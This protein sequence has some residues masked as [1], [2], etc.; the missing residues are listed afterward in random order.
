[1]T[2]RCAKT[3]R[4]ITVGSKVRVETD[5]QTDRQTDGRRWLLYVTI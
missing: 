3:Q 1:M 2:R 5:R 4:E